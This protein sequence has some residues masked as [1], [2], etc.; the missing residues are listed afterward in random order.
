MAEGAPKVWGG[1][2]LDVRRDARRRRLLE[3]GFELLGGRGGAA[4][5]VRSVCRHAK[6]TDRYFYESFADRE[7]L[8]VAVYDQ[9][10]EEARDVLAGAVAA[11]AEP[12]GRA[13]PETIAMAAVEAFLGLLTRDPRKGRV[14]LLVPMTDA[15]LSARAV[16]LMPMFAELIRV[17]LAAAA[18]SAVPVA[19]LEERMTA[20]A[21]IGALSNLFIRWLDGT[22]A[23]SEREL[24]DYCVRLLL[25]A[26]P[27]ADAKSLTELPHKP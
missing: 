17:Q 8:L 14:L 26:M 1:T 22:L 23:A 21:L 16:E 12:D 19:P 5:T 15:A 6:L 18:G 9:V 13:E 20:T 25:T 11:V 3:V 10:A 24:T 4:V 27:L 7:E 2:T